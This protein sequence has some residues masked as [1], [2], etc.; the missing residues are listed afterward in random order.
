[1]RRDYGTCPESRAPAMEWNL[2]NLCPWVSGIIETSRFGSWLTK[3]GGKSFSWSHAPTLDE[4]IRSAIRP[5][6]PPVLLVTTSLKAST[7]SHRVSCPT[8]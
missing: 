2:L 6:V 5:A 1:M 3:F 7:V 8:S 4:T